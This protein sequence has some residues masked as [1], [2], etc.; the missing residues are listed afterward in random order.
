MELLRNKT[1]LAFADDIM[2]IGSSRTKVITKTTYLIIVTYPTSLN[3]QLY[4]P[5]SN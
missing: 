5:S 2:M 4:F 1:L 3:Y